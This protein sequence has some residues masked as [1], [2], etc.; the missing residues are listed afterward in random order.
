MG[1]LPWPTAGRCPAAVI[2][3][4]PTRG[5]PASPRRQS[6]ATPVPTNGAHRSASSTRRAVVTRST[7]N[8][9]RATPRTARAAAP[10]SACGTAWFDTGAASRSATGRS[11]HAGD[12]IASQGIGQRGGHGR[13]WRGNAAMPRCRE[14]RR[15]LNAGRTLYRERRRGAPEQRFDAA[16]ARRSRVLAPLKR[17][18]RTTTN[19][20]RSGA[21]CT[22]R[23]CDLLVR[24]QTLYPAELRALRGRCA[25]PS[26]AGTRAHRSLSLPQHRIAGHCAPGARAFPGLR[27]PAAG[28]DAVRRAAGGRWSILRASERRPAAPVVADHLMGRNAGIRGETWL[29]TA[30]RVGTAHRRSTGGISSAWSGS[31]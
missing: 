6:T 27:I 20:V 25:P 21:P 29:T 31:G 17:A 26:E 11:Q 1:R 4:T 15:Q 8:V 30:V 13:T 9:E 3:T 5:S 12:G 14:C 28:A 16:S 2:R 7:S 19:E 18:G 23:T 22:I 10:I 24:S